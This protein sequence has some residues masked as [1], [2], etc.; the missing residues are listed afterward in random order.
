M[1]LHELLPPSGDS[2][3]AQRLEQP[4]WTC[5]RCASLVAGARCPVCVSVQRPEGGAA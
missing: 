4:A 3:D 5:P 1:R 2:P